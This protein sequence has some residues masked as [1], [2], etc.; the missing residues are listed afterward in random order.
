MGER[1]CCK[2]KTGKKIILGITIAGI[3]I[4]II[5][6]SHTRNG[7]S[8]SSLLPDSIIR[9]FN[10]TDPVEEANPDTRSAITSEEIETLQQSVEA[11]KSSL[12]SNIVNTINGLVREHMNG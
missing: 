2:E 9:H 3:I 6:Y 12:P 7:S 10:L 8:I 5:Y 4:A 1:G 11:Y